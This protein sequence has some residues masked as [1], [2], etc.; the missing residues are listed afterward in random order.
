MAVERR[1][2]RYGTDDDRLVAQTLEVIQTLRSDF[3]ERD[4]LYREIDDIVFQKLP[5]DIPDAYRKTSLEIHSPLPSHMINTVTAALSINPVHVQFKPIKFGSAGEE[6]ATKR[7]HFFE[8]SWARQEQEAGRQLLRLFMSSLVSKGEGILKTVERSKRAWAEYD[9]K[10]RRLLREMETSDEYALA[11]GDARDRIYHSKTEELKLQMPYPIATTD[12]PPETFYYLKGEDGMT[13]ACEVK[14]VPYIEAFER[15][16]AS[17]DRRGRVVAGERI[18]PQAMGLARTEWSQVMGNLRTV[19]LYEFWT[20]KRCM[21]LLQGPGQASSVSSRVGDATLVR[22][23]EHGYGDPFRK[24]LRGPYFHALGITTASRLPERAGLSIL[25]G[26]L[27]LFPLL[28]SLLTGKGNAAMMTMFP[29]FKRNQPAGMVPGL[30]GV[31]PYGSDG[32]EAYAEEEITPGSIYPYDIAPVEQPAAGPEAR[33]LIAMVRQMLELA[34]PSVVQGVVS[35]D[36]SG[37]ALNQAAHLARLAWDPTISNA[38]VALGD[39]IGFESWLIENKIGET[40]YAWGEVEGRGKRRGG[41][42]AGWFGIGPDDLEGVHR[43]RA[44]L[45]PETP[46]NKVI[47][48]RALAEQ[49]Q[50]KLITYE[51]AVEQSGANPDEVESSWLLHDLKA[52]DEIQGELKRVVFEKLATIRAA[53]QQQIAPGMTPDMLAGGGGAPAPGGPQMPAGMPGLPPAMGGPPQQLMGPG[54][55]VPSPGNGLPLVP[56]P[57]GVQGGAPGGVPGA[58][59]VPGLPRRHVPLPGQ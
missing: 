31:P 35:G 41:T 30:P 6:N 42:R 1:Q 19:R 8:A 40:V 2:V 21:Y 27:K 50:L 20:W 11:D 9:L 55:G 7:E 47:E 56:T 38:E 16:G 4:E 23:V 24:V 10:S 43:Y 57:A 36:E 28:D 12:V 45:D 37:Y 17:L 32:T 34:L 33:E 44:R 14:D 5:V 22:S 46:S 49:M 59:V 48:T 29:A 53:R 52:S 3:A 25:H 39:R 18:D 54:G 51:D 58:P 13:L 15:F 26:F